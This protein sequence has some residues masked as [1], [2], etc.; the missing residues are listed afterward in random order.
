MTMPRSN[1]RATSGSRPEKVRVAALL[2]STAA[3]LTLTGCA[4]WEYQENICSSGEYPVLAVGSTGS[5]CVSDGEEPGAGYARYPDGKMPKEVGDKWDV[6]WETHTLDK[7]GNIT[8]V[9]YAR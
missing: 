2:A 3:I 7:D 5:A 1:S 6:Y 9:P 8:D 4:G